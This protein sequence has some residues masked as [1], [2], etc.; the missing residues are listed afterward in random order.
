MIRSLVPR[1]TISTSE[2]NLT[3]R[4][5]VYIAIALLGGALG[6]FVIGWFDDR[7]KPTIVI[8]DPRA[9]AA[10]VVSVEGAV[11]T[12]GVYR[13]KGDARVQ[14]AL[15]A[16]GG[17]TAEAD[18]RQIN[19]AARLRDGERLV[20]PSNADATIDPA[21]RDST[22]RADEIDGTT[23]SLININTASAAMLDTLPRIGPVL[24]QRIIAYREEHGPFQ[25]VDELAQV[26]GISLAM[27]DEI[28]SLITV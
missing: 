25:S 6:A 11:V 15:D 13:L 3:K 23:A 7:E 19:L 28:R 24:A 8:D 22:P 10:I 21:D 16:A 20:I 26:E 18:L 17:A 5:G 4:V 1:N 2:T 12:P 14:D 9:D 27:V